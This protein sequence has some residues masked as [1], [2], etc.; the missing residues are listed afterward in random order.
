MLTTVFSVNCVAS[1]SAFQV[2]PD[3]LFHGEDHDILPVICV[4]NLEVQVCVWWPPWRA[5]VSIWADHQTRICCKCTQHLQ[6][7][8]A[9]C[10]MSMSNLTISWVPLVLL[11]LVIPQGL[12]P[13]NTMLA[14]RKSILSHLSSHTACA[15]AVCCS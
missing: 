3:T 15:Q 12:L 5:A 14:V 10:N 1:T 6:S 9:L 4:G 11:N 7:F 8:T 13:S 2:A